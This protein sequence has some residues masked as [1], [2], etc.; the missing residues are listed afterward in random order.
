[1]FKSHRAWRNNSRNS[2][3]GARK[4]LCFSILPSESDRLLNE[5]LKLSKSGRAISVLMPPSDFDVSYAREL[6]RKFRLVYVD[7]GRL[8]RCSKLPQLLMMTLSR[9]RGAEND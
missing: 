1:M 7:F 8:S 9:Q 6:L 3:H 4:I 5:T 2:S